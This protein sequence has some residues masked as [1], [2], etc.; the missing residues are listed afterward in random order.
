MFSEVMSSV[1]NFSIRMYASCVVLESS[2]P[3]DNERGRKKKVFKLFRQIESLIRPALDEQLKNNPLVNI[4]FLSLGESDTL[5]VRV[6][7][8]QNVYLESGKRY[9]LYYSVAWEIFNAFS[10]INQSKNSSCFC[11]G[12][13]TLAQ[14]C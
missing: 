4:L 3:L 6:Q 8:N 11:M 12:P 7:E 2:K 5:T 9:G 10:K 14:R 13:G 1:F